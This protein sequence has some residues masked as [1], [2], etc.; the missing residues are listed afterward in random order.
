MGVSEREANPVADIVGFECLLYCAKHCKQFR[1]HLVLA[2][3]DVPVILRKCAQAGEAGEFP[4]TFITIEECEISVADGE[5]TIAPRL[6]RIYLRVLR[7]I[8]RF[9]N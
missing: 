7:A 9:Q 6:R 1:L 5:V 2:T 3:K 4:R 8:H